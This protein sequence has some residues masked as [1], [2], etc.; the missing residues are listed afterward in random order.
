MT[1]II[2]ESALIIFIYMVIN[3]AIGLIKKKNS[4]VDVA[5]GYG[6]LILAL[7]SLL[8]HQ[9][10][11]T[12]VVTTTLVA[13]WAIRLSSRIYSRNKDKPED[14]RYANWR[15][16]WTWFKTR[17][18]FQIY[19]LQG[20]LIVLISSSVLFINSSNTE[21]L[22]WSIVGGIIW[23]IGYFFEVRGDY[24]LDEFI[25]NPENKGKILMSGLWKYTRHPNYFGEVV[26]WWGIWV[27]ALGIP[28]GFWTII[29]PLTITI[30]ILK[31]SGIPMLEARYK[32]DAQYQLYASKT[33]SFFPWKPKK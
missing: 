15:A 4:I 28:N 7:Y 10:G 29:S 19:M 2:F 22:S 24:E 32:D 31:V 25:K 3:F 9:I 16:T 20:A 12:Q 26:M 14:F 8:T 27:I 18:F 17:S 1:H 33:N 13:A 11:L 5:Y 23:L 30:L 6:F 21:T